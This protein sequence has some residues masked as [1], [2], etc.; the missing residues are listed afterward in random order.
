M[1]R[2]VLKMLWFGLPKRIDKIQ[3]R[4]VNIVEKTHQFGMDSV[5]S[6]DVSCFL[7]S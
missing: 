6:Y 7:Y 3:C 1:Y 2:I 5:F 4:V